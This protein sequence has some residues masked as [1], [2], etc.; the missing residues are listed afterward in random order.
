[1]EYVRN[2]LRHHSAVRAG[3]SSGAGGHKERRS[4]EKTGSITEMVM[5]GLVP[6]KNRELR[7]LRKWWIRSDRCLLKIVH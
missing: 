3:R 6:G 2:D 5:N 4:Q 1:M 7:R